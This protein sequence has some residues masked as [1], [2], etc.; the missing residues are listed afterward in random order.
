MMHLPF[1]LVL[2]IQRRCAL[3]F[4]ALNRVRQYGPSDAHDGLY[5]N[6]TTQRSTMNPLSMFVNSRVNA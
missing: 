3:V 6:A 4:I 5:G 2:V 1:Q